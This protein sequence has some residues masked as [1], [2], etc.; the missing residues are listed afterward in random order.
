[1]NKLNLVTGANCH[2]GNNLVRTLLERGEQVRA[3]VRNPKNTVPIEGLDCEIVQADL[4]DKDSLL[5]A[6]EGMDTLYQVAAVFKHW[7]RDPQKE[8]IEPNLQGT[9]NVL[10]AAAVQGVRRIVYVSSEGTLDR[11]SSAVNETHWRTEFHGSHY[12]LSKAEFERLALQ[13]ADELELDLL[14]VLPGAI[15]GPHN[16]HLTPTMRYM[17]QALSGD[18]FLDVNFYLNFI[19][20]DDLCDGIIAVA[21]KGNRG[22]RYMLCTQNPISNQRIIELAQ[23]RNPQ[24]KMP[25]RAPKSLLLAVGAGMEFASRF[26]GQAPMMLRSQVKI[27]YGNPRQMDISKARTE[28]GFDPRDPETAIRETFD[29]LANRSKE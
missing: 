22:E 21:E 4:M 5:C 25:P 24:I 23:E 19:H 1:M 8:I 14:T 16:F 29:Y 9:R 10:Q 11:H 18:V 20:V 28:L 6:L 15:I 26:T 17:D 7:A 27:M 3:T 13:L 2:L 12:F